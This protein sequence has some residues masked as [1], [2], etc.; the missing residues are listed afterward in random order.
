MSLVLRILGKTLGWFVLVVLL[1]LGG[2]V[3]YLYYSTTAPTRGTLQAP[4]LKGKVEVFW[5]RNGVPHIKAQADDLDAFFALGYVHAQDR[6]W[7]MDF[8]RRV[9]A[10]RLSEVLGKDTLSEDRFLRTWGF[11]RAAEQAYPA[12]SEHTRKVLEAYTAG[13]NRSLQQG[14]LPLEFTL[15]GYKPEPWTVIDT[16]SWQKMMA[17]DL[18]GNWDDEV[19]AARVRQKL[20]ERGVRE[21]F[22][23]YPQD[24]PTILSQQEV[25]SSQQV[26]SAASE[27]VTL[28]PQSLEK[29]WSWREAQVKLGMEKVPD[30]GSNN[31]VV[32]GSRTVSGKPLLADD[33][34]LSLTAPSLW[35]L[36]ELQGPTLHVVG[37]TI[38][39][40][41]AVVIGRNDQISWGVTNTNPDVEDLFVEKTGVKFNIRREVIRV[42]GHADEVLQ[43]RETQH[44]PVVS[45]QSES[46]RVVGDTISLK[47]TALQPGDTTMDAFVGINYARNWQEFTEALSHFVAPTQNFVFAAQNGDIG[48]Y[49]AGK[50]PIRKGW[51]GSEPISGDRDWSGYIPFA[52]LPHVL[53]PEK[54]YIAS[55][56][57]KVAPGNYPYLLGADPV[58]TF[59]YRKRRIEQLIQATPRHTP[60]TFA[61]IQND[62]YS[63]IWQDLKPILLKVKPANEQEQ[64]ALNILSAWDGQQTT[65][66][67]GSTLFAA[68]YKQLAEMVQDELPFLKEKRS[69]EFVVGQLRN[70]GLYCKSPTL[71]NCRELLQQGL[72]LA[73]KDLS[74]R[75]GNNMQNWQWGKL[76]QVFNKHVFDASDQVRWLFNRSA[77][78]P[79]GLSTVN[80]G[81][82]LSATYQ[83]VFG[84]SYRQIVDLSQPEQSLFIT[85]L[86]QNGNVLSSHYSNFMPLWQRG[87]YITLS[88]GQG[89]GLTLQ[90]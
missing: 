84:P 58:W 54:G 35:Y 25:Q 10:G 13:V 43:V 59:P 65:D 81:H 15:L 45:D 72:T 46:A 39:G 66:S 27:P 29:V 6:L 42:K 53:N 30:K 7:Q 69:P 19:L 86:G 28:H 12:L 33:P 3:G 90:P 48:Y 73:V 75:L 55:A 63:E 31:W 64:Q 51:D 40:M 14:K 57:E 18:G 16:L 82:Y 77:A 4:G 83:Q 76:H 68:W 23:A 1:L 89:T 74:G 36:A 87:E 47:W 44:G 79:G 20:G 78:S 50:I 5:D 38:P 85:T 61:A 11:Y 70:E 32:S 52:D 49:A 26:S 62:V 17:F 60:E 88:R 37:G 8:Q 9:A 2:A 41:P 71:K 67:V 56:N 21:L 22:P 80:V 34:H 24:A